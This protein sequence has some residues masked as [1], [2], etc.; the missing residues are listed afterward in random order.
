MRYRYTRADSTLALTTHLG[1]VPRMHLPISV[2]IHVARVHAAYAIMIDSAGARSC[3]TVVDDM[4]AACG[5]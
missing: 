3:G 1:T 5:R 2:L 4:A